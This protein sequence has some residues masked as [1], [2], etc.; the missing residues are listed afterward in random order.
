MKKIY[1]HFELDKLIRVHQVAI[2]VRHLTSLI[3]NLSL[4]KR[5][6]KRT[7]DLS[8]KLR[9]STFEVKFFDKIGQA[10]HLKNL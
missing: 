10:K 8:F 1:K 5:F 4:L 9:I 2:R 3:R 7:F 6:D